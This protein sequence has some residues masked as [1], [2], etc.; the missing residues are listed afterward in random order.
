[1]LNYQRVTWINI[2]SRVLTLS[3]NIFA[4]AVDPHE[5]GKSAINMIGKWR[6][7]YKL[8]DIYL[9]YDLYMV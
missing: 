5:V 8:M 6:T 9:W 7:P 3:Y 4:A 1:M 2:F